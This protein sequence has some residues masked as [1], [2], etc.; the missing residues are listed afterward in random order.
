MSVRIITIVDNLGIVPFI[1]TPLKWLLIGY[2]R[3]V[4]VIL[5]QVIAPQGQAIG[6]SGLE[7]PRNRR[8]ATVKIRRNAPEGALPRKGLYPKICIIFVRFTVHQAAS[9]K[10]HFEHLQPPPPIYPP[11]LKYISN[12]WERAMF[13]YTLYQVRLYWVLGSLKGL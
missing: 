13:I 10:C 2:F 3:L 4:Q 5:S 6:H 7:P 11:V 1:A 8:K 12:W 9:R